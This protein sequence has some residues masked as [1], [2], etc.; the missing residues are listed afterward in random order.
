MMYHSTMTPKWLMGQ[1]T[2]KLQFAFLVKLLQENSLRKHRFATKYFQDMQYCAEE[3][4][5][6]SDRES[7]AEIIFA[8]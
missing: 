7:Q 6:F 4:Q 8:K 2:T 1:F 3:A 5:F